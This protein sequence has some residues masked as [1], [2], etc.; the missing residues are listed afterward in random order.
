MAKSSWKFNYIN[1]YLYKNHFKKK[2]RGVRGF[3]LTILFCRSAIVNTLFFGRAV[4]I[5]QGNTILRKCFNRYSI[6]FK[7]G[8]F[9][10]TR[11]SFSFPRKKKK[12][13]SK[14]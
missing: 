1:S 6:G 10:F 2:L 11:K 14:R 8:E 3:R 7:V 4:Y 12:K 9:A 5:H 13:K